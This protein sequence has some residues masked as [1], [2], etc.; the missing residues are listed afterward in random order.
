MPPPF[1]LLQ[2]MIITGTSVSYAPPP[3]PPIPLISTDNEYSIPPPPSCCYRWL[4][5]LPYVPPPLLYV[6]TEDD[7]NHQYH[8]SPLIPQVVTKDDYNHQY[9]TSPLIPHVVTKDDYNTSVPY[10]PH[11]LCSYRWWVLQLHWY[12][13][14][15]PRVGTDKEYITGTLVPYVTLSYIRDIWFIIFNWLEF[16]F[17][18][19]TIYIL[20]PHNNKTLL[21][22]P[23]LSL[24]PN[25][26]NIF[27]LQRNF[28]FI[29]KCWGAT[30]CSF[31]YEDWKQ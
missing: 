14:S 13:M 7:Y 11:P 12:L 1:M 25:I 21:F 2:R 5:H 4:Y 9:H 24:I 31:I 26:Y 23:T 27:I 19:I 28:V 10:P 8:T 15:P 3:P 6:A 18:L 30:C 17:K 29:I 22:L 16:L 20:Q